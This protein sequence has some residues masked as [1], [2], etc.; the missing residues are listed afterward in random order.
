MLKAVI[1]RWLL[2][3]CG[4]AE[5]GWSDSDR[6]GVMLNLFNSEVR[7]SQPPVGLWDVDWGGDCLIEPTDP[8]GDG[9]FVFM[10]CFRLS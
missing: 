3:R 5:W 8:S 2:N 7:T 10:I 1:G 9:M 4:I 6:F